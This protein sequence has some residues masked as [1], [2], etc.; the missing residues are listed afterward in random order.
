MTDTASVGFQIPVGIRPA[1]LVCGDEADIRMGL[2]RFT[3]ADE[4]GHHYS[5]GWRCRDHEACRRRFA[6]ANPGQDFPLDE[7]RSSIT[8]VGEDPRG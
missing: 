8:F 1:C 2:M 4:N 6:D 5:N 7:T 3:Q